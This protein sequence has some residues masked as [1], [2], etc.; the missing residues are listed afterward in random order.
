MVTATSEFELSVAAPWY[1]SKMAYLIYV[2][3]MI[4]GI[5]SYLIYRKNKEREHLCLQEHLHAEEMG[6]AKV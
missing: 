6:E 3:L 2:I 4:I 1:A 5:R